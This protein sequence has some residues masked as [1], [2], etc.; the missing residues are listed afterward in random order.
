MT[1]EDRRLPHLL[2]PALAVLVWL[3]RSGPL[4]RGS[5][6]GLAAVG[7]MAFGLTA[8]ACGFG[9][10][11]GL[12]YHHVTVDDPDSVSSDVTLGEW[13]VGML[14]HELTIYDRTGL[15]LAGLATAGNRYNA[16]QDAL[17]A[18]ARSGTPAGTSVPY[19]YQAHKPV[20]G[21]FT[22]VS[23]SWGSTDSVERKDGASIPVDLDYFD[24]DV[25][26]RALTWT[27]GES[28]HMLALDAGVTWTEYTAADNPGLGIYGLD[29]W[30]LGIPIGLAHAFAFNDHF[31]WSSRLM[32]DPV[33]GLVSALV[34]G[35]LPWEVGTRLDYRF[36]DN[37]FAFADAQYRALPTPGTG[38]SGDQITFS[39]GVAFVTDLAP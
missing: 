31:V 34:G 7:A 12:R 1:N 14:T 9:A 22:R 24:F 15:L 33:M 29:F 10:G 18:A 26:T 3:A 16:A 21:T 5:R 39:F 19:T 4:R 37:I 27:L 8:S 17:S 28:N 35:G 20:P 23:L 25:R 32:V 30:A 11:A 36:N 38:Q 13:S 2:G 6:G